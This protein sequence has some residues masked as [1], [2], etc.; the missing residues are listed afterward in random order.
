GSVDR[1]LSAINLDEEHRTGTRIDRHPLPADGLQ[2]PRVHELDAAW[3]QPPRDHVLDGRRGH[4]HVSIESQDCGDLGRSMNELERDFGEHAERPLT[5]H[6][7]RGHIVTRHAFHGP[8]PGPED[9]SS[10]QADF[11]AEDVLAG[12]SVFEGTR[13]AGILRNV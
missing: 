6:E 5:A 2:G 11:E 13:A 9:A 1:A 3:Y 10:H 12:D 7:Q 4:A 8:P